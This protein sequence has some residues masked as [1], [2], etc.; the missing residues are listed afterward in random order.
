MLEAVLWS[1]AG[2]LAGAI[3]FSVLL[4]KCVLH[5]DIRAY[6]DGNPGS[7]NV[8]RAG[9]KAVGFAALLLDYL[10]GAVP[11]GLAVWGAG[12]SGWQLTPVALAPVL[13]HAFSPFLGLRG[14]KAIAT[15]FGVWTGLTVWQAPTVLRLTLALALLFQEVDGWSVMIGMA[16]SM[17]TCLTTFQHT[18]SRRLSC[19][20][21]ATRPA[22]SA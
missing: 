1:A 3:P 22:R 16:T 2:F 11:V 6:G 15:T 18:A 4:G 19:S 7:A 12:L 20:I 13:G 5:T 21:P 8:T 9:G 14:G 10:K 17:M